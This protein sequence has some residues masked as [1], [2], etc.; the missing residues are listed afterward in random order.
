MIKSI[1]LLALILGAIVGISTYTHA[2]YDIK[3]VQI[4]KDIH[5]VVGD[6]HPPTQENNGFVS[7]YCFVDMGDS[8]VVLDAGPTYLFA[9][10]FATIIKQ[11]Y[12]HKKISAVVLSNFHDDR[13]LGASYFKEIGATIIAHRTFADDVKNFPD[14]FERLPNLLDA[15]VYAGTY[16]VTPD[17]W[18]DRQYDIT[19]T[20]KTLSILKLSEIS[21][22]RSDIVIYSKD[23]SFVFTGNIIFNNRMLNYR[24]VSHVD[25]WI[26]ALEKIKELGAQHIMAGHGDNHSATSYQATLEYLQILRR[27]VTKAY[28][29]GLDLLD[30]VKFTNTQK[31]KY[32]NYFDRLNYIAISNYYNQL[33]WE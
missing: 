26:E 15:K 16:L 4:T 2:T 24:K 22:E 10:E 3:P 14:K 5:C 6:F 20:Q 9:K 1:L 13:V 29:D 17:V 12:P 19:G 31:F 28:E 21:E 7:N 33:E 11:H 8:I 23:D 25:G 30:T 32:L 27:D 18:T